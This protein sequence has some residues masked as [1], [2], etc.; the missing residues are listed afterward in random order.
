ME[1]EGSPLSPEGCESLNPKYSTLP[2]TS[3]PSRMSPLPD[4]DDRHKTHTEWVRGIQVEFGC[5]KAC[6]LMVLFKGTVYCLSSPTHY[7]SYA[8][9]RKFRN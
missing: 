1:A 3:A 2:V 7:K 6:S 8:C 4:G 9:C 5:L